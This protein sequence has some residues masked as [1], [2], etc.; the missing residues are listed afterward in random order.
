MRKDGAV[1]VLVGVFLLFAMLAWSA[2][3]EG[4]SPP[5]ESSQPL[6]HAPSE[7]IGEEVMESLSEQG[8]AN[9]IVIL[10]DAPPQ[11]GVRAGAV[12]LG[13]EKEKQEE[14]IRTIASRQDAVLSRLSYRNAGQQDITP[15][16]RAGIASQPLSAPDLLLKRKYLTI[17]AFSGTVSAEGLAKLADD[18]DVERIVPNREVHA[19]LAES[20]AVTNASETWKLVYNGTNL[21]GSGETVCVIDTGVDYTHPNMG[22]CTSTSNLNDG[23]CAKVPGGYDFVNTDQNPIDD[24]NHGTHVAGIVAS[25]NET[26]RGIAPDARI[27]AIKAL[28]SAGNGVFG[29]VA[30]GIE[31]CTYNA[32]LFNV[33]VISMSLGTSTVY[34]SYCDDT[35]GYE[36]TKAAIDAA[37]AKNISVIAASGNGVSTTGISSPACIRNA[38]AVGATYDANVGGVVYSACTDATSA[39]DKITCFSNRNNLTDLL[40]PGALINSLLRGGGID[41]QS[42]TSMAAPM[43]AGAFALVHQYVKATQNRNATP[44]EIEG[45]LNTTGTR[46]TDSGGSGLTFSRINI[47][48]ALASLD[49][50]PPNITFVPPTPANNSAL[51]S[52]FTINITAGEVLLNATLEF[53]GTNETMAGSGTG[54]SKS[55]SGIFGIGT[56]TVKIWANDTFGNLAQSPFFTYAFDTTAPNITF[57]FPTPLNNTKTSNNTLFINATANESLSTALLEFNGTNETMAGSGT[58]WWSNKTVVS[59]WNATYSYRVW[60]NDSSGNM[61][62]TELRVF[63][64]NNTPPGISAFQPAASLSIAEESA[65]FLFNITFTDAENDPIAVTWRRNG[66]VVATNGNYSFAN[67]FSAAGVYDVNASL[68]DGNL[69]AAQGWYFNVTNNNRLPNLTS[70]NITSTD[71]L[72]RKN[73]TLGFAYSASD[74][75]GESTTLNQTRWYRNGVNQTALDNLTTVLPG[76]LTKN[77]VWNVSLLVFDGLNFS[78]WQNSSG[79]TIANA[80]PLINITVG[81]VTVQETQ[82]VNIS[83]NASD[84]DLDDLTF[85]TNLSAN[86]TIANNNLSALWYTTITDAGEYRVNITVND[87]SLIDSFTIN[88]TVVDARDADGLQ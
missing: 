28:D 25:A 20:K 50:T 71:P 42:G 13:G 29:D 88:I 7:K 72:S 23:S 34:S 69:T 18:P 62:V 21:T 26:Y 43:V 70:I 46:I 67:N 27:I 51:P 12:R 38:T 63:I 8:E 78:A 37:I 52:S 35:S 77:D 68:S 6:L 73:G 31:W 58:G 36:T 76:N 9:V 60:G 49:T 85:T 22:G 53:N 44:S 41:E 48:G 24:H 64:S 33:S 79:F 16:R 15:K 45:T 84:I 83:L 32:S 10:K 57:V 40:A 4:N 2:P 5:D 80:A 61:G 39:T 81:S 30:A 56:V 47:L 59:N 55:K 3:L 74:A 86:I 19:F 54:W 14:R 11:N 17:N 65:A 87:S 66:T 75:D 82:L 1:L